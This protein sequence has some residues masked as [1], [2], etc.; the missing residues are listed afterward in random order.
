MWKDEVHLD[1]DGQSLSSSKKRPVKVLWWFSI[2]LRLQR[3]LMSQ[4]TAHNMRWHAK[5]RT[6][7]GVLRHLTD[8]ES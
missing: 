8:S 2:I 6:N 1:E 3:L 7:D 4:C 5:G